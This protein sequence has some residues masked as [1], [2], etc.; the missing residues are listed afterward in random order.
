MGK[1]LFA[2]ITTGILSF[3]LLNACAIDGKDA[4]LINQTDTLAAQKSV[5]KE[6][7]PEEKNNSSIMDQPVNFSTH[8]NVEM[9]LQNIREK[10]GDAAYNNL[11]NAMRYIM[12]Y[13]LSVSN[14]KE[15]MYKKLN[16][17]TPNAI[18]AKTNR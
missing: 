9:T 8:E 1:K 2:L 16:G 7:D 11:K 13:D 18:I 12:F 6:A 4:D 3:F 5:A 17:K 14:N 10:E 15:K